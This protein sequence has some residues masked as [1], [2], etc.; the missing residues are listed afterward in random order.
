[1]LPFVLCGDRKMNKTIFFLSRFCRFPF[2]EEEPVHESLGCREPK[3]LPVMKYKLLR[4]VERRE[5]QNH[6]GVVSPGSSY[7]FLE[8]TSQDQRG[9]EKVPG[10][11]PNMTQRV[12]ALLS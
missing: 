2:R 4:W 11:A 3:S 5:S 8:A 7:A 12:R 6:L 9:P 10:G 1:M